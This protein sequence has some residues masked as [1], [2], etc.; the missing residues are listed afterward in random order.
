VY[1]T[2]ICDIYD[3]QKRFTQIL[4]ESEGNVIEAATDQW[5]DRLWCV[6]AVGLLGRHFE[7]HAVKL[8]FIGIICGSSEH[9]TK[10]SMQFVAFDGYYV[11]NVKSWI[12]VHMHFWYFNFNKVV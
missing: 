8:L 6:R 4:V 9:F 10:L 11:V 3:L 5:R 12:C 1:E 7:H 2:K